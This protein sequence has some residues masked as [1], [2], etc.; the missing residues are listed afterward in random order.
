MREPVD[1]IDY[2]YQLKYGVDYKEHLHEIN[3][4]GA[5]AYNRLRRLRE[6]DAKKN[7]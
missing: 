1:A 5:I 2:E 7:A 3:S 6:E 4:L